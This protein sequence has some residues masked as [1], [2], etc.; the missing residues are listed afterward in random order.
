ME[1]DCGVFR[2]PFLQNNRDMERNNDFYRVTYGETPHGG[3]KMV[4]YF[5]DKDG[6]PCKEEDAVMVTIV[7]LDENDRQVF[8]VSSGE[9]VIPVAPISKV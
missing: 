4:G 2:S 8:S 7:E 5:F 9:T 1:G 6:M 3:V